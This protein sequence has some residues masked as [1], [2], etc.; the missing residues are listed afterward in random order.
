LH[1]EQCRK[2]TRIA[3]MAHLLSVAS[4]VLEDGGTEDDAIAAVLHDACEDHGVTEAEI[5]ARFG[6]VIARTV[7]LCSDGL[8][9]GGSRDEWDWRAR[10]EA[11]LDRL[12][13]EELPISVYRVAAADKLHNAR[14]ILTDLRDHGP[15]VWTRFHAGAED[16]RWYYQRVREILPARHPGPTTRELERVVDQLLA[17]LEAP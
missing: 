8:G 7:R 12:E 14:S 10:K 3:Y 16:Q 5:R 15:Q 6:A 1:A 11:Y 17:A 13:H 9:E 2:G 4:L